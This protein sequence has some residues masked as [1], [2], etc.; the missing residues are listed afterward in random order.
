MP[1]SRFANSVDE[2]DLLFAG[3]NGFAHRGLHGPGACENSMAAFRAAIDAGAGIE[4]DLRLSRD[5]LAMLFHDSSLK[6][7]C[8]VDVETESLHSAALLQYRLATGDDR[9]ARLGDLLALVDGRVPLLL[10]LKRRAGG[11]SINHLCAATLRALH[12]YRGPV[13][14][15][16]FDPRAPAWFARHA[17]HVR[18]GLVIADRLSVVKRWSAMQLADPQF[19]SVHRAALE[20][21]W[22]ARARRRMPVTSW[23]IRTAAERAAANAHADALIWEDDGRPRA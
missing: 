7:L 8:G 22:V 23:T 6:R 17:P 13:G 9:I 1:S 20:Q 15:M 11:T 2:P 14:V 21:P 12:G 5:G 18:R 3:R 10:E 19:L 16:S 4:C